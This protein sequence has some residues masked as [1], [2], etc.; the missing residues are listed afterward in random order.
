MA[1]ED[2]IKKIKE[3]C[4]KVPGK[5]ECVTSVYQEIFLIEYESIVW[6]ISRWKLFKVDPNKKIV[7]T[8]PINRRVLK[9]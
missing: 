6:Q 2:E 7:K 9:S 5:V 1:L 8:L 4:D 3:F